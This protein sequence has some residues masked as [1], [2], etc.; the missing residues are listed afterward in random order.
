MGEAL[1]TRRETSRLAALVA[2][3]ARHPWAWLLGY[4]LVTAALYQ[5][6]IHLPWTSGIPIHPSALDHHIPL[7]PWTAAPYLTYF[8]LMPSWVVLVRRRPD[9]ARLMWAAGLCVLGNLAFN[10]AV[11]SFL[12]DPLTPDA[13][14][15]HGAL[16][17]L[18]VS[19]DRPYAAFPSGHLA[20]PLAL[21]WLQSR[22]GLQLGWLYVPWTLVM[23]VS[24]LTTKQHYLAD[25]LGALVYGTLAPHLALRL[26]RSWPTPEP[27]FSISVPPR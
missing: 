13:A 27:R 19:H 10:L 20:L 24:I 4:L 14:E 12:V 18:I 26:T 22:A 21:T 9:G 17:G 5:T 11:P 3:T 23:A 7:L 25:A 6:A 16:L 15:A 8:A 2:W 1:V